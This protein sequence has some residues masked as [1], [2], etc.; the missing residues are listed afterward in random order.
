MGDVVGINAEISNTNAELVRRAE[1]RV[2]LL[3][4]IAERQ[5]ELKQL[6]AEDKSDGFDEKALSKVVKELRRGADYQA[7]QLE[8]ELVLDA[9]RRAVGL[10]VTLEDA[11]RRV[12][13]AAAGGV[14]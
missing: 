5:E 8:L 9:Y 6:K 14:A 3:D 11:Q 1:R 7:A 4:E 13:V 10:P 12:A 2:T